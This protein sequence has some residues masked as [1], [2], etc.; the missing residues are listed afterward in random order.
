MFGFTQ[1]EFKILKRL[2]T[3]DRVQDF[4]S[5]IRMNLELNGDVLMSPRRVLREKQAHCI[6]GALLAATALWIQ[7]REPLLLDIQSTN[8]DYDHVVALFRENDRWG[9]ISK[10][11]H[12]VLRYREPVYRSYHELAMSY[13]HEYFLQNGRKTMRAYSRPF[14][15]KKFGEAW[16]TAEDDLWDIG[17]AIDASPH[18]RVATPTTVKKFRK[19]D[20][21]EVRM[22]KIVEWKSRRRG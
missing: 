22:G 15:L 11:N 14:N 5:S 2:N 19:A 9:A 21:I 20:P 3:P 6:E 12:G 13:F 4:L 17:H 7:G 1:K 18:I 16:M 8:D 10:T